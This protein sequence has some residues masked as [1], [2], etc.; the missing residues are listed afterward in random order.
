[1]DKQKAAIN[2][3]ALALWAL[4]ALFFFSEYFL[5]VS[6]SVML[7]ELSQQLGVT[8]AGIGMF[9]ALFYYPYILMQIP[10]GG[11]A[12]RFD[13][14]K[15]MALAMILTGIACILFAESSSLSIALI[16]RFIMGV[17][18]AFAFVGTLRL[19]THYFTPGVL[20]VLIGVTQA[21]GMLGAAVG[22]GPLRYYIDQAGMRFSM[23]SFS[24][25]F[26]LLGGAII[27]LR[28]LLKDK[29]ICNHSFSYK[30]PDKTDQQKTLLAIM[31]Q[32]FSHNKLLWMNCLF[33][34]FLYGPTV[35]FAEMWGVDFTQG[36]HGLSHTVAA[37]SVSL[38]FIG[39]IIGCSLFGFLS[40]RL[41]LIYLMRFSAVSSLLLMVVILYFPYLSEGMLALIF[42]LYGICNAG[43]IPAYMRTTKLV[44]HEKSGVALGVTNMFSILIGSLM[45]QFVGL[46]I[47][48]FNVAST[49][50]NSALT[51]TYQYTFS[52]LILCFA[53]AVFIAFKAKD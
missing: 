1:M 16:S 30:K 23:L 31:P 49:M 18:A 34:G 37:F 44:S 12:D 48:K 32:L 35:V 20:A 39:M 10:V 33:I 50:E 28:L 6:P 25:L 47:R 13:V 27:L 2:L 17:C 22:Q 19:A 9:S 24:F 43:I 38:I 4:G 45:I 40:A 46:M 53:F 15:V 21:M 26:F 11:I 51:H 36:F 41:N 7:P 14:Q 5:R 29:I 52:L 8:A 42:L 3:P